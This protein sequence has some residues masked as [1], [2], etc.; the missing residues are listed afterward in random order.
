MRRFDRGS[1]KFGAKRAVGTSGRSYDS[2]AERDRAEQLLL[3]QRGRAIRD[4]VE[5]PRLHLAC[6]VHYKPDFAY[7]EVGGPRVTT[8]EDVKGVET[9]RFRIVKRL[10][11]AFGPGPLHILKRHGRSAAFLVVE[12]I[13]PD[14]AKLDRDDL[15]KPRARRVRKAAA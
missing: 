7:R 2:T 10:W 1:N 5:Q 14:V 11:A 9:E 3:L 4:L 12:I 15:F 8:Y 13:T 6:G